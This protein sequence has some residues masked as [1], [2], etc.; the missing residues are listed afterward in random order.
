MNQALKVVRGVVANT[1]AFLRT[2]KNMEFFGVKRKDL[3]D[4]A[5]PDFVNGVIEA[6]RTT[7]AE[8]VG[9]TLFVEQGCGRGLPGRGGDTSD[10][11]N[12]EQVAEGGL[13]GFRH[14]ANEFIGDSIRAG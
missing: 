4:K 6:D 9:F 3:C 2:A 7:I 14:D 10:P 11:H 5:R 1:K 13:E 12:D 8:M